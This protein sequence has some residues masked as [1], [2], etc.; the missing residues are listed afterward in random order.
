M[1]ALWLVAIV[2]VKLGLSL[3]GIGAYA[4]ARG[5]RGLIRI[6]RV[7]AISLMILGGVLMISPVVLL[8]YFSILL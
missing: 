4:F 2:F 6:P 1:S 3:F 8:L 5:A 7:G